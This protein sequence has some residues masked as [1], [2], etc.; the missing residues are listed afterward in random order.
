MKINAAIVLEY[1][2][3]RAWSQEELG[4]VSGL[5]LRTIQRVGKEGL[6]SLETKKAL[7]AIFNIDIRDLDYEDLPN[8]KKY[9]YKKV[10]MPF[11]FG[12]F[13]QGTPDIENLLN[14]EGD[15]GWRLHQIVMPATS[16][17]GQ[18]DRMIAIFERE[19]S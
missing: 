2:L 16:N 18:S 15:S 13:K 5:S 14:A 1:R 19:K 11:K 10:E 3:G 4:S 7:A 9:E 6:A 17:M 12:I 8:M